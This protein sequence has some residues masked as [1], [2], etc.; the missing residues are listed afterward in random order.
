MSAPYMSSHLPLVFDSES[1]TY[2]VGGVVLPSVTQVLQVLDPDAFRYVDG[3]VMRRAKEFGTNVH[4]ACELHN[5]GQLDERDLDNSLAP[6]LHAW[7]RFINENGFYVH[8]SEVR[9]HNPTARYAGTCDALIGASFG[10]GLRG[11]ML[12]VVDIKSSSPQRSVGP[13]TAAYLSAI[14][15]S[16]GDILGECRLSRV[17]YCV[18]LRGDGTYIANKLSDTRDM[19]IFTSCLN[20]HK[21]R[22]SK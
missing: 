3:D 14:A 7:I 16:R 2:T 13:Q 15:S 6:Y 19:H 22:A 10:S 5:N 17:R 9:C 1:H 8:S 11:Q 4:R 20:I 12:H 18:E 21:W